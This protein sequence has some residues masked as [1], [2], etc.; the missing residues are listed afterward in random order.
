[1]IQNKLRLSPSQVKKS[2]M[3]RSIDAEFEVDLSI[4]NHSKISLPLPLPHMVRKAFR[5]LSKL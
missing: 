4:G 2:L 3:G 5:T 1:M